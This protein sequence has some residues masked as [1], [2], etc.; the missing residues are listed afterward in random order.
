VR[1]PLATF[2]G[3][4]LKVYK[5]P[6]S[7]KPDFLPEAAGSVANP[8]EVQ[9]CATASRG[10][11]VLN[12]LQL[13]G[14]PFTDF[15]PNLRRFNFC[16]ALNEPRWQSLSALADSTTVNNQTCFLT[17]P[18]FQLNLFRPLNKLRNSTRRNVG[19]V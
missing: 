4:S 6:A 7:P 10:A 14:L 5:F 9:R 16:C 19:V 18:A 12:R 17:K 15:I 13:I 1:K 2:S 8:I 3:Y 11:S